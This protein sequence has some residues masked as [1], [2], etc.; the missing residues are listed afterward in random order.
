MREDGPVQSPDDVLVRRRLALL[1]DHFPIAVLLETADRKVAQTNRAFCDM[2]SIPAPPEALVGADCQQ[3]AVQLA[4]LW[5]DLDGFLARV[6][7]ILAAGK[8]VVGERLELTDGRILERDFLMVPIDEHRGEATWIY[9][10]ITAI[11]NARRAAEE[12]SRRRRDLLTTISH[13]VRTPVVGIVGMVDLL[14]QEPL[15]TRIRELVESVQGSA[16]GM[17]TMLDNMLDLARVEADRLELVDQDTS[18]CDL[19][20]SVAAMVGP[21]AQ[22]K[23]LPLIASASP[24][25]PAMVRTDPGRL[26]QVLLN[27]LSNAVKFTSSGAV[28]LVADHHGQDLLLTVTDTG[29]G[30]AEGA[31]DGIFEK[32]VQGGSRVHGAHGGAGLGLAISQRL[33]AA[34][35][36]SIDVQSTLG[37]GSAFTVRLPGAVTGDVHE[38]ATLGITAHVA[39]HPAAVPAVVAALERIG[40]AVSRDA[41]D[42]EVSVDVVVAGSVRAAQQALPLAPGHRLIVLVPVAAAACPPLAG[43]A[44]ALPWTRKRLS[45]ALR[46]DWAVAPGGLGARLS[47]GTRVLLAED[48]P[49][50]RRILTEMLSRL[51]ASVVAVGDGLEAVEAVAADRFD[52][53]LLDL[54]MPVMNGRDAAVEIRQRLAADRCPAILALTADAATDFSILARSGFSGQVLKPATSADLRMAIASAMTGPMAGPAQ[55]PISAPVAVEVLTDLADDLGDSEVVEQTLDIY[56]EELPGRLKSMSSALAAER[57][58]A[59][60]DAAH[61][62]KSSSQMLGAA[63]LSDLC[64][65]LEA[66][67]AAQSRSGISSGGDLAPTVDALHTEALRVA[68]WLAEFREA[69]YPGLSH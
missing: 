53:V 56:L 42:P 43:S 58:E 22:A 34:L 31:L 18:I 4:P 21:V 1:V 24:N 67:T 47:P 6:D 9:R 10:D 17:T 13:D 16:Q 8:P 45:A 63:T 19:V 11:D 41:E 20:E 37:E 51:G 12:D 50:N 2:F 52:V 57:F 38:P 25:L 23:S 5:A 3:A 36:G 26:R 49:S 39:G 35:G 55:A 28:T 66:V 40:V 69:G 7:E 61:A 60:R 64:R 59:L 33:T 30:I 48:E 29:P 44:V 65:D 32:F 62:L 54:S 27:L 15:D 46:D 68:Q 14:L